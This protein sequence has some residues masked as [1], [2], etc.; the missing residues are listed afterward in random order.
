[1]FSCFRWG[2]IKLAWFNLTA[3]FL[4]DFV[5]IWPDVW[6]KTFT[7]FSDVHNLVNIALLFGRCDVVS[8]LFM[9]NRQVDP[10]FAKTFTRWH[11]IWITNLN[12]LVL[13]NL[14][15][16]VKIHHTAYIDVSNLHS[17]CFSLP[18]SK[19]QSDS[20]CP[21]IIALLNWI[22]R[23]CFPDDYTIDLIRI[24]LPVIFLSYSHKSLYW[25]NIGKRLI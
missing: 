15:F 4:F 23:E 2:F 9:I 22:S 10:G 16:P 13:P 7:S 20:I 12:S 24:E 5:Y 11:N 8:W 18:R 1:M 6:T 3:V 25:V 14:T 19:F 17:L 21:G